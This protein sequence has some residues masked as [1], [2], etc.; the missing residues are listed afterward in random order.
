M[1]FKKQSKQTKQKQTHKHREQIDSC[2]KG[3]IFWVWVK[4]VKGLRCTNWQLQNSHGECS[5]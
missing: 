5:Q 2:Q 4:K 1:E 3:W